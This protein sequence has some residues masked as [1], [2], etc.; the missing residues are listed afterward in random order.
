MKV[1]I[2]IRGG[3]GEGKTTAALIVAK[4]L[5]AEQWSVRVVD[6][7]LVV[8]ETRGWMNHAEITTEQS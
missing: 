6:A 8:L 4:A 2:I 1:E 5:F 7:E 3:Q